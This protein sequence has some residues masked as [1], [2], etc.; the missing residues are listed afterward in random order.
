MKKRI[1]VTAGPQAQKLVL[2]IA[3]K[4][5]LESGIPVTAVDILE[6]TSTLGLNQMLAKLFPKEKALARLRD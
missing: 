6:A 1:Q 3:R 2:K 5:S 4:T